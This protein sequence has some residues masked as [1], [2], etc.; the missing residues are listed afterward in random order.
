[1]TGKL[2]VLEGIEACGKSTQIALL[3]QALARSGKLGSR[4][5]VLVRDPGGTVVGEQIRDLFKSSVAKMH[6]AAALALILASRAQLI[7]EV[8]V[9]NLE[10]GNIVIC[11]R[12]YHST[13]AYQGNV[14]ELGMEET[15]TVAKDYAKLAG[16]VSPP[17][18]TVILKVPLES[19]Q[20]RLAIRIGDKDH[21][22]KLAAGD[23]QLSIGAVRMHEAYESMH[24]ILRGERIVSVDGARPEAEV[25]QDVLAACQI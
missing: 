17:D 23:G 19:A 16:L 5:I 21:F 3:A 14:Q 11:D 13:I 22:D 8:I 1:M 24:K 15:A 9:P 4:T 18:C 20:K 10:R 2:F 6:S 7:S 12:F 25:A